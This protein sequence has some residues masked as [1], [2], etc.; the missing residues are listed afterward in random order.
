MD[1]NIASRVARAID[2]FAE[3]ETGDIRRL[4][5]YRSE[6]R[7]RVGDWRIRLALDPA[8]GIARIL[9]VLHRREAYRQ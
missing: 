6:H 9:H 3:T 2:R 5:G 4:R 8:T 7:L 1:R